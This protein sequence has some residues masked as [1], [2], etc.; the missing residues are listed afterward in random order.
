[1]SGRF[2]EAD[3]AVVRRA[4]AAQILA[5]AG[6][7]DNRALEEAFASVP[8]ERFVGRPPWQIVGRKGYRPVVSHDPAVLYQDI[9]F[10][11]APRR[12]VNN[13]SPVLHAMWLD[14]LG[15]LTGA[16]VVHIG[17]GTGYYS[18]LLSRLVG[19]KGHVLAVEYDA[20]LLERAERNLAG[21]ENVS[22][23][24]GDGASLAFEPVDAVYVNFAG[25]AGRRLDR[26]AVAG[27]PHDLPA[28]SARTAP[29]NL[30]RTAR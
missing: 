13:G 23:V 17:A 25:P 11:L 28:R 3:L 5:V 26:R 7:R 8:R 19:N 2:T 22:L 6:V 30:R 9:N 4:F 12:G 14:A 20:K 10:A 24:A 21:Y 29:G 27:W 18:A 1:L 15:P 16:R